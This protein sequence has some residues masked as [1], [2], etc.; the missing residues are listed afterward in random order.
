MIIGTC[1]L[2]LCPH[3]G[4]KKEIIRLQS[5][6]SIGATLWSD[7]RYVAPMLPEISPVQKCP[8]CGHFFL[9][10][11]VECEKGNNVSYE[12][13]WL[14][15]DDSIAAFKELNNGRT[16][17]LELLTIII[18]WAYNDMFRNNIEPTPEQSSVFKD[19]ISENL[20]RNIFSYNKMFRAELYR[21]IGRFDESI[22]LLNGSFIYSKI[23]E[24][25]SFQGTLKSRIFD[26]C[27]YLK[28]HAIIEKSKQQDCKVFSI[29]L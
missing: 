29:V 3:C 13:G 8:T 18:T 12:E 5:G 24:F 9:L 21:E 1:E 23:A 26:T 11:K 19:I 25:F 16:D 10:S 15:F 28:K 27:K 4:S 22:R 20:K 14:S 17:R 6:N 7:A 2:A